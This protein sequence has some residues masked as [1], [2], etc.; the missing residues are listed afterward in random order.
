MKRYIRSA[1]VDIHDEHWQTLEDIARDP[2]TSVDV[3]IDLANGSDSIV[4]MTVAENP[5]T[6]IDILEMLSSDED[7]IVRWGVTQNPNVSVELLQKLG[8]DENWEVVEGVA[9]NEKTSIDTLKAIMRRL[10]VNESF[11][12]N[13]YQRNAYK[14]AKY[15]LQQV[16][17]GV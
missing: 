17:A 1:I 7:E 8:N 2:D 13:R 15:K 10:D 9:M 6:P 11:S 5:N 4:K 16:G 3:L 12:W 14:A